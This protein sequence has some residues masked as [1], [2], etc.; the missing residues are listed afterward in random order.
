MLDQIGLS[1]TF[2]GGRL[3]SVYP[4]EQGLNVQIEVSNIT[5]LIAALE[6]TGIAL[7]LTPEGK[8]YRCEQHEV[9][10]RQFIVADPDGYLLRFYQSLGA[11]AK[12]S[13]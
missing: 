10:N 9:G 4:F 7:F 2:D 12:Q 5:P 8:W 6:V 1:R 11:R 3:P 13:D